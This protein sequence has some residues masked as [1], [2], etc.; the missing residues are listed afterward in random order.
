MATYLELFDLQYDD[1][2]V[3]KV[4]VATIIAAE[5]KL[6]GAPTSAEADWARSVIVNPTETATQVI[7]LVLAANK[8]ASVA[9]ITGATD[10]AIQA[11]VDSVVTGL[12]T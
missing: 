10:A 9:T 5:T 12:I 4:A 11:N 8:D 1:T 7:N 3:H 2:L 6:S